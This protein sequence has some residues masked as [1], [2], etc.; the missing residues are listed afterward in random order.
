M[1]ILRRSVAWTL[2]FLFLA[3]NLLVAFPAIAAY[4]A[5]VAVYNETFESGTGGFVTQGGEIKLAR[6][7][8][9]SGNHYIMVAV[10][11]DKAEAVATVSRAA[12][13]D[14]KYRLG[15]KER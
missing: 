2:T 5:R 11:P 7:T 8:D 13:D 6:G 14:R 3:A 15:Y 4:A 9:A 12:T 1:T 10:N